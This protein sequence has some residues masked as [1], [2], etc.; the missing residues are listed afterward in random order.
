MIV[1]EGVRFQCDECKFESTTSS[2]LKE[3]RKIKHEGNN[4]K[5]YRYLILLSNFN[6]I[7][8]DVWFT[9]NSLVFANL[10]NFKYVLQYKVI[11]KKMCK[12][13]K[14]AK[15]DKLYIFE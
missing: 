12:N 13:K 4:A 6:P 5:C 14:C 15:Y 10:L 9:Q 3:H 7:Q 11:K 8:V 1:H 2:H